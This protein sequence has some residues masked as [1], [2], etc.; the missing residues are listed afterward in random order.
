MQTI[1]FL[2]FGA[3]YKCDYKGWPIKQDTGKLKT[4]THHEIVDF[5]I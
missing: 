5:C 3:A 2:N 4:T 1:F